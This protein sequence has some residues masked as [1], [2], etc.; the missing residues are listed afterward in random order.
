MEGGCKVLYLGP[1]LPDDLKGLRGLVWAQA[2]VIEAIEAGLS[3]AARMIASRSYDCVAFTSPRGPRLLRGY[4]SSWPEGVR[5]LCVGPGTARSF[6]RVFGGGCQHPDEYSTAALAEL[7][8]RSGCRSLLTLR[9][10]A[11]DR[12]LETLASGRLPVTRVNIYE[13]RVLPDRIP[14]SADVLIATSALIAEAACGR[15][16]GRVRL[17]VSIGPKA[18]SRASEL[19]PGARVVVSPEHSFKALRR[20]LTASG[21]G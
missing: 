3:E 1:E 18:A 20:L 2:T 5:A 19:C 6:S 15:L 10:S 14:D 16:R 8:V 17:I 4:L 7:A 13:E 9:S 21:C 12:E 11:G